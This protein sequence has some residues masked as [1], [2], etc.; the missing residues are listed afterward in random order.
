MTRNRTR[1]SLFFL[2]WCQRDD[3][4]NPDL[5]G[6]DRTCGEHFHPADH[7]AIVFLV[8]DAEGGHRQVS[9]LVKCWVT[10]SLGRQHGVDRVEVVVTDVPVVGEQ[11]VRL[12]MRPREF[13]HLHRHARDK[14]GDVIRRPPEQAIRQVGDFSMPEHTTLEIVPRL[15]AQVVDGMAPAL[16][17]VS[18]GLTMCRVGLHVV[19]RR[20]GPYGVTKRGMRRDVLDPLVAQ[21]DYPPVPQR[22]HMLFACLQHHL[23]PS[24]SE[25]VCFWPGWQLSPLLHNQI[26]LTYPSSVYRYLP[27]WNIAVFWRSSL[28]ILA[29]STSSTSSVCESST[30][31]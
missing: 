3:V 7:H 9:L 12:A 13:V 23:P 21:I 22:L 17:L 15:R 8:H 2:V 10:G 25:R 20:N 19:E 24:L 16:F 4:A 5:V 1:D 11:M 18:H 26:C 14:A 6:E 28:R 30:T 27:R 31:P 29:V